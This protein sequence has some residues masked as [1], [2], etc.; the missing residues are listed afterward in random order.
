MFEK[1]CFVTWPCSALGFYLEG[2]VT[3]WNV[4]LHAKLV[5]SN[6]I[7]NLSHALQMFC[8]LYWWIVNYHR[9]M[10]FLRS[11]KWKSPVHLPHL[12]VACWCTAVYVGELHF[13]LLRYLGKH[14]QRAREQ[15]R[16]RPKVVDIR[17]A[18]RRRLGRKSQHGA[19]WQQEGNWV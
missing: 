5:V 8:P 18:S 14:V 17:R 7:M 10:F 13:V 2:L 9:Q 1:K 15:R 11:L 16:Q 4:C 12:F 3:C 6:Q 19:G